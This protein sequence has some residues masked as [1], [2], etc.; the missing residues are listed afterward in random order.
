MPPISLG[1]HDVPNSVSNFYHTCGFLI[2]NPS[3]VFLIH[4]SHAKIF[5][6]PL[7]L[8]HGILSVLNPSNNNR[9]AST[10]NPGQ[11]LSISFAHTINSPPSIG[12]PTS[13]FTSATTTAISAAR[14]EIVKELSWWLLLSGRFLF[15]MYDLCVNLS[16][17]RCE[18]CDALSPRPMIRAPCI[19]KDV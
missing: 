9:R 7:L 1:I 17:L 15:S 4:S 13:I 18:C 14:A 12:K 10:L 3:S 19:I 16:V 8:S 11:S 6:I 2:S 5:C